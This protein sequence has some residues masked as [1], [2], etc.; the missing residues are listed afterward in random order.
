MVTEE[1]RT[2]GMRKRGMACAVLIC[3]SATTAAATGN[4]FP[5]TERRVGVSPNHYT[6]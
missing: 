4:A 2:V 3:A 1:E 6:D 5:G